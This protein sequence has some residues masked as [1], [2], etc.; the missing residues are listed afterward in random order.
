MEGGLNSVYGIALTNTRLDRI[1]KQ[2][3]TPI[4]DMISQLF[5]SVSKFRYVY[6]CP[7]WTYPSVFIG[8]IVDGPGSQYLT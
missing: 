7:Q 4:D 2:V 3:K 5:W 6:L 1:G 8:Y